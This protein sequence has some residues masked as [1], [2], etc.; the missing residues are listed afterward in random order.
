[1]IINV[2]IAVIII[3]IIIIENLQCPRHSFR[4]FS[5]TI[6]NPQN[7][8]DETGIIIPSS[9]VKKPRLRETKY[10]VQVR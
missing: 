9:Q 3:I 5:Y 10:L 7:S 4:P 6:S 1:M 2:N 8:P